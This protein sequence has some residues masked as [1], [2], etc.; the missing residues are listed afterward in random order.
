MNVRIVHKIGWIVLGFAL[1]LLCSAERGTAHAAAVPAAGTHLSLTVADSAADEM[2]CER[3]YNSDLNLL[4]RLASELVPVQSVVPGVR[5]GHCAERPSLRHD[6]AASG[7]GGTM[8][9]VS[10]IRFIQTLFAG[11][12][13][14]DF[15][16]Y[17]LHRLII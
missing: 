16:V 10:R 9:A 11:V 2:R 13:A 3:A 15:Y 5:S 17:R 8:C 14:V 4:T 12:P 7:N 6:A 1:V